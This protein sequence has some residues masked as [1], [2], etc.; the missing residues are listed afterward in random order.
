MYAQF[1]PLYML[2]EL[3]NGDIPLCKERS[4]YIFGLPY[5]QY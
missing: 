5:N 2:N 1:F 4:F 3:K